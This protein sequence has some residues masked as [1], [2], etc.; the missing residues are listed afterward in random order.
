MRLVEAGEA[1]GAALLSVRAPAE[2]RGSH[3]GLLGVFSGPLESGEPLA[4]WAPASDIEGCAAPGPEAAPRGGVALVRRGTCTF[5][6]KALNAQKAGAVGII[7]A[8]DS[9]EV[10]VMGGSNDTAEDSEVRIFAVSVQKSFGDQVLAWLNGGNRDQPVLVDIKGYAPSILDLSEALLVCL[11]TSLVAA[12]ASFS[13]ADLRHGSPL[14][15]KHDEVVE[16]GGELAAGFCVLGSAMLMVLYFFMN[17]MIYFIIFAFCC[18]GASCITQFGSMCLQYLVPA[19]RQRAVTVPLLG[20]VPHADIISGVPAV[21]LVASWLSLRNTGYGWFFQDVIGAGFLCW[22]QRTLRLPNI[23]IAT[24]LLSAMFFFDIFWVFISPLFFRKSVMVAVATGGDTGEAVPMLLRVPSIG[25]PF[26][27]DRMLGFGD[28][29]LPGLL[30]SFL[31]RHDVLSKRR[32]F[33]GYFL[34]SLVGYFVGLCVTIVALMIMRMGQ[35]ALLYLVPGT[36]GTTLLLAIKRKELGCIWEGTPVGQARCV[37]GGTSCGEEAGD[38]GDALGVPE[39][40]LTCE[41]H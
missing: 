39:E 12:G 30:V 33:E 22:L 29:A 40:E 37:A 1:L 13:T 11:A 2:L 10:Q 4:V 36:L 23:K 32:L 18:G 9:E 15:P 34:P 8:S 38:S 24:L 5:V 16:V 14:A 31:R 20:P 17:Y 25:D 28:I 35:P 26:G 3:L 7:V 41:R 6:A 19:L 27:R 21:L